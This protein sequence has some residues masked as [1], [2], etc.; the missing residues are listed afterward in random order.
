MLVH[1]LKVKNLREAWHHLSFTNTTAV[2][3]S[4][5]A[6]ATP[7]ATPKPKR[8]LS[9]ETKLRQAVENASKDLL[10]V[11]NLELRLEVATRWQKGSH[12]WETTAVLLTNRR[13][14]RSLDELEAL[15]VSRMFEL[16][17]M[18]MSQTGE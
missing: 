5:T 12:E 9:V 11:Q 7:V 8:Q 17:K 1:S 6:T 3:P 16:T 15:I 2:E 13:Y 14:Q 10:S 4:L 18:N